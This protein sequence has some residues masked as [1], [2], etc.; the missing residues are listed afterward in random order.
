MFTVCS[1]NLSLLLVIIF[2]NFSQ[3]AT[4]VKQLITSSP[5]APWLQSWSSPPW[6]FLQILNYSSSSQLPKPMVIILVWAA[7]T[8]RF[9]HTFLFKKFII[10]IMDFS[11]LNSK[12]VLKIYDVLHFW[13]PTFSREVFSQ[14]WHYRV[15]HASLGREMRGAEIKSLFFFSPQTIP[16]P[17]LLELTMNKKYG[18]W[19]NVC[20]CKVSWGLAD[21]HWGVFS[22]PEG[23]GDTAACIQKGICSTLPTWAL[24]APAGSHRHH[25]WT[26][27]AKTDIRD[28]RDRESLGSVC[29][30]S[31]ATKE[32]SVIVIMN[33]WGSGN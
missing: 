2:C 23:T 6:T 9:K 8:L 26:R 3:Q 13:P 10:Y 18:S 29:W 16:L 5:F 12:H 7:P 20:G 31:T 19:R 24:P 30:S 1:D 14:P 4:W 21:V 33:T 27:Q 17:P 28:E 15:I 11:H 25:W 32:A 22:H